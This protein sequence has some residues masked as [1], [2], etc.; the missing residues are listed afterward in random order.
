LE[1]KKFSLLIRAEKAAQKTTDAKTKVMALVNSEKNRGM[2]KMQEGGVSTLAFIW[3]VID[4][5]KAREFK[6]SFILPRLLQEMT[7][8]L[9]TDFYADHLALKYGLSRRQV[10][11]VVRWAQTSSDLTQAHTPILDKTD[12]G[13]HNLMSVKSG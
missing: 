12:D 5:R 4:N 2:D 13:R 6:E 3:A 7:L 1:E 8:V 11:N 9:S 10:L